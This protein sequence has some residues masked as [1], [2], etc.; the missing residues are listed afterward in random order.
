[1]PAQLPAS[2]IALQHTDP[3][4]ASHLAMLL[5]RAAPLPVTNARDGGALSAGCVLVGFTC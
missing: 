4:R 2:L 1:M 5:D 3:A